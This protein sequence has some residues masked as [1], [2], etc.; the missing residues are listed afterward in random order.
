MNLK[1][2][3][4][5]FAGFLLLV[6]CATYQSHVG[7]ARQKIREN[8]A[9][10]A[11]Q[12]L[13][14][15]AFTE[16]SDQLVYLL[17]YATALQL[18]GKFKD[19]TKAFER[20]EKISEIQDYHS[21]SKITAS[22]VLS[23]EMVQYK[24]DDFEKVL[25]NALNAINYLMMNNLDEALVEAKRLN[26]KLY[27]YKYEAKK[28]YEQNSFALYLSAMIWEAQE[29]WDDAYIAYKNVFEINPHIPMLREDLL[30]LAI[31]A[32]RS[33]EVSLWKKEFA[34]LKPKPE[35][36]DPSMGE[37]VFILQQGWGPHKRPRPEM[38]R[39][40]KLYHT[41]S[42]TQSARVIVQGQSPIQTERVYSVEEVAIKTLEDDYNA[43]VAKR[44]GG[45][46]AKEVIADQVR[47]KNQLLGFATWVALHAMDRADLR[48]WSTVPESFQVARIRLKAGAYKVSA[49]G[50]GAGDQPT[51][52]DFGE[53]SVDIKPRK[54]TFL[55]WRT[56]R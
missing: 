56:V 51:G 1:T 9:D 26:Q 43:L 33:E 20:A 32:S 3:A 23:E 21:I 29:K 53:Q 54:T 5:T 11:A 42:L 52:E 18:G 47:Q 39:L 22:L 48:Q 13:E 7:D 38:P 28:N 6:G 45:I 25:I 49:Q 31:R 10:A 46:V 8:K 2:V 50:L 37:L 27:K 24:G 12:L 36:K 17:D 19:S 30:R 41:P 16:D 34:N 14:K 55:S 40:P 44:I 35:W 4:A 15:R